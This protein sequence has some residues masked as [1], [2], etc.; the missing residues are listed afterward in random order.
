MET[1]MSDYFYQKPR[2]RVKI[3]IVSL[4]R[5]HCQKILI[6]LLS[7]LLPRNLTIE[8][9]IFLEK[10]QKLTVVIIWEVNLLEGRRI[11]LNVRML[12]T[13]LSVFTFF[14]YNTNK[15]LF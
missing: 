9:F 15:I 12:N 10:Y 5:W 2:F 14:E 8:Q 4:K 3:Q 13:I 6:P 7:L 1:E 11:Y